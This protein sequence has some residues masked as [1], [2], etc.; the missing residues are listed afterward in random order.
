MNDLRKAEYKRK[1]KETD[2]TVTLNIDGAGN[3]NLSTGVG[4]FDHMLETFAKHS[5]FDI[6]VMASGDLHVDC[7]HTVEDVGICLGKAFAEAISDKSG[8]ARYGSFHAPMDE[9]L[10]FC[11]VDISGRPFIVF[12]GAFEDGKIGE[13]DTQATLE[14]FRAFAFNALLTLHIN[15][16]YGENDHHK[17]ESAFKAF[18][19]AL[20]VA[21]AKTGMGILSAKGA[22]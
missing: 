18:A 9:A 20:A 19:H 7:H 15:I 14:F 17:T 8:I 12:N 13:Y 5:G 2:I 6:T 4:F 22:L 3:A 11:A 10:A 1:T 21:A 16:L